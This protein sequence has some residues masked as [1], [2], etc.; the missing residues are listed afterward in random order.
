MG[1]GRMPTG[2]RGGVCGG[3][4]PGSRGGSMG[5]RGGRLRSASKKPGL[6]QAQ[7]G[8]LGGRLRSGFTR[9]ALSARAVCR[10]RMSRAGRAQRPGG[11]ARGEEG[12]GI[13]WIVRCF[14]GGPAAAAGAGWMGRGGREDC[15]DCALFLG[16][17]GGGGGGGMDGEGWEGGLRGLCVVSWE[18]RRRLGG[19]G[20][21]GRGGREDCVDC[22]LFLGRPGG[23]GAGW[24]G[25]GAGGMATAERK[26]PASGYRMYG[27]LHFVHLS[28]IVASL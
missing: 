10:R 21:M 8:G 5:R 20:W 13:A 27:D 9:R 18:A 15:V 11:R 6:S 1:A 23:G 12:G 28:E 14:L 7:R 26:G 16:R 17:P 2:A 3:Q 24:M 4:K 19:A 25:R 22:A